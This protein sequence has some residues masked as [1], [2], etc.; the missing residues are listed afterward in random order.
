[1]FG[2]GIDLIGD[3]DIN[4]F[5]DAFALL[6]EMNT[7][8]NGCSHGHPA[9]LVRSYIDNICKVCGLQW[10]SSIFQDPNSPYYNA[11]WF[12]ASV[13]K[14]KHDY[15]TFIGDDKPTFVGEEFLKA[16]GQIFN[17]DYRVQNG[18]LIL[19]RRDYFLSND[20]L[21]DIS[22]MVD[23]LGKMRL[24]DNIISCCFTYT[25]KAPPAAAR[26]SYVKD[27]VD[28]VGNEAKQLYNDLVS[29][30]LPM[31]SYPNFKGIREYKIPLSPARFRQDGIDRDVLTSWQYT[32]QNHGSIIGVIGFI[33]GFSFFAS[34]VLPEYDN[35][36]LLAEDKTSTS[37]ILIWDGVEVEN[38][39]VVRESYGDGNFYY[40]IPM[41]VAAFND[42]EESGVETTKVFK[43]NN[44]YDNFWYIDDPRRTDT[45]FR[46]Y[47]F[48]LEIVRS[49][50]FVRGLDFEKWIKF[51][52]G[53]RGRLTEVTIKRDTI[54]L[55]GRV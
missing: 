30:N 16:L 17:S 29:W 27:T 13:T 48:S 11:C 31:G 25:D 54:I 34:L 38:A 14:G 8:M 3:G 9:P 1:L 45:N 28:W 32:L 46:G 49:C 4:V 22:N 55:K 6:D 47:Y 50:E 43:P 15:V 41:W 36:L 42:S 40:N 37:K 52:F 21:I 24:D 51:P 18:L 35:A 26:F 44:L 7:R 19:E 2:A 53:W 12:E 10:Q 20:I 5:D 33:G 23:T 39:K